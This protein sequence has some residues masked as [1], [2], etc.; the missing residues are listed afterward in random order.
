MTSTVW[1]R[2]VSVERLSFGEELAHVIRFGA[3]IILLVWLYLATALGDGSAARRNLLPYQTLIQNSPSADQRMFRELQEGLLEA[4][5]MRST[6]GSW[7]TSELLANEGIPP[8]ALDPTAKTAYHWQLVREGLLVNYL[9]V[10]VT[11]DVPAWLVFV[12]EPAP[13]VP[14]DQAFED[15]E[16]HRLLD[17]TMLHVSTWTH[18]DGR[19][20]LIK[21]V[22]VPQAEGW[23]Q[24]YAVGPGR[25]LN[26]SNPVNFST[27][28]NLSNPANP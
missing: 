23:N 15:E 17:G 16:H 26:P 27:P 5:A 28:S 9:G 20:L 7:P 10:P 13:G 22:R 2:S 18:A 6:T 21:P 4:E 19:R 25:I 8:F 14:P 12:Q 3:G 1:P 24:L 11:A